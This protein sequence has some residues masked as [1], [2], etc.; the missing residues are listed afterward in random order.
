MR[1]SLY[2]IY[3][4]FPTVVAELCNCGR[5][6]WSLKPEMFTLWL[7]KEFFTANLCNIQRTERQTTVKNNTK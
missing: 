2:V 1:I 5:D 3:F 6:V 4:Y 7:F